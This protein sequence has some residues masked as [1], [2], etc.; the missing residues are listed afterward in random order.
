MNDTEETAD[1]KADDNKERCT[2][3]V[4]M[5]IGK[6]GRVLSMSDGD[7]NQSPTTTKEGIYR[8]ICE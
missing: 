8:Q 4:M 5:E 7:D 3:S 2:S 1:G 6:G